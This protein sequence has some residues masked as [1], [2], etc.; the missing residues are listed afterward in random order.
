MLKARLL[1]AALIP[2]ACLTAHAQDTVIVQ[3][4]PTVV[5]ENS[6]EHNRM[7]KKFVVEAQLVGGS[8]LIGSGQGIIAGYHL[9][10]NTILQFEFTKG[11]SN[12]GDKEDDGYNQRE[13]STVAFYAKKFLANSFYVKGGAEY[14]KVKYDNDYLFGVSS[15]SNSKDAYGFEASLT[16]AALSIGNQWQW[17]NFTLGC[18]WIGMTVPVAHEVSSEYADDFYL[19]K[20]YNKEDQET[21]LEKA[22]VQ[23]LRF[24]VGYTF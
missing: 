14:T 19:A 2:F 5:T 22:S 21:L 10:R 16:S 24:Y 17:D 13:G 20:Q 18:D 6:S 12:T 15:L 4:R 1:L 3:K 7:G 11:S 8:T 9:D 23:A